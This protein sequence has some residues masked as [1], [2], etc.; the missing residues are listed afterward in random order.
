MS[1]A[2]N[3][4][5]DGADLVALPVKVSSRPVQAGKDQVV[6][7]MRTESDPRKVTN[8]ALGVLITIKVRT[9]TGTATP[10]AG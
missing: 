5:T 2:S 4:P 9:P 7:Q 6:I 3:H 8:A 10:V 1:A